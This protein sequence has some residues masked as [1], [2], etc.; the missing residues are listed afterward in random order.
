MGTVRSRC[1]S[2]EPPCSASHLRVGTARVKPR[3]FNAND[4]EALRRDFGELLKDRDLPTLTS[5]WTLGVSDEEVEALVVNVAEGVRRDDEPWQASPL[6]VLAESGLQP[7]TTPRSASR[8]WTVS[9]RAMI[10]P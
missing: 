6:Q 1:S 9:S 7:P 2:V 4:Q 5:S 8:R 10:S 3:V